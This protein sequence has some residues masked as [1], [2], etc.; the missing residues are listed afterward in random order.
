[1]PDLVRLY[2]RQVLVGFALSGVLVGL[3]LWFDVA[4]LWHLVSHSDQG[5][6][7]VFLL[8]L[9]N[10]IVLAAVQFAIRIMGMAEAGPPD[11][12][13]HGPHL[14]AEPVTL[15]TGP[16]RAGWREPRQPWG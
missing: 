7:A 14:P 13:P 2:I 6:L 11:D 1:M 10:G 4:R 16:A 15:R 12:D 9:F 8:W 3:L 5:L